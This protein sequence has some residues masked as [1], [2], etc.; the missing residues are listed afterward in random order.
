MYAVVG[1][2][3]GKGGVV[4]GWLLGFQGEAVHDA[5]TA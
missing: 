3:V 1:K 4:H 2:D 5:V